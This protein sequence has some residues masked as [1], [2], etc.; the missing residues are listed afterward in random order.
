MSKYAAAL[1]YDRQ[2]DAAPKVVAKGRDYLANKILEIARQFKVPVYEDAKLVKF[3]YK[4]DIDQEIPPE[5]YE[6]VARILAFV[7]SLDKK[8]GK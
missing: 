2:K 3:L 8:I 6:V 4:L 7:Y 5:V 1:K